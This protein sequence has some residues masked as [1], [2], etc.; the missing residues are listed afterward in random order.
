MRLGRMVK[1]RFQKKMLSEMRHDSYL[2]IGRKMK[3][4]EC[5]VLWAE[6]TDHCKVLGRK[7]RLFG[8][9]LAFHSLVRDRFWEVEV[10]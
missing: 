3:L 1:E 9:L 8:H 10:V 6:R 2:C 7:C 5:I 4:M